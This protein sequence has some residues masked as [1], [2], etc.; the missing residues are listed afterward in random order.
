M[1][2]LLALIV[3]TLFF[4]GFGSAEAQESEIEALRAAVEQLR[5]D[6]D[7]RIAELERRLAVA[8]QSAMQAKRTTQSTKGLQAG[9]PAGNTGSSAFNPAIGVIFQGQA[10]NFSRN[11]DDYAIPGF[12]FGGEAGPVDEGLGI[13]ETELIL[14]ANVDDKFTAWLTV[15][16][17]LED[18]ESVVEI[19]EAWVEATALP[20]GLGMKFGRFFSGIGYLNSKHAHTWDFVDQPLPYQA[21]LGDQFLDNGLQFRWLAPTDLYM[22]FGGEVFQGSRYPAGGNADSGF[23]S[24]SLF[25]KFGGDVGANS[26]WLAGISYLDATAIDR[27]SGDEDDPLV[28][29]GD[30]QLTGAQFVWKWSPNGNWKQKN[31]VF[32]SEFFWRSEDGNYTLPGGTPLLYDVDQT[33]WY[34]QAVYQ[35]VPRWRFGGRVDGLSTDSPGPLFDDSVLSRPGSNPMRYSMMA[36]WSNSEFSRLRLQFTRDEAGPLDDTQWGIQYIHSIGAH[37]AHAF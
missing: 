20:A 21:F 8:E 34:A 4:A 22:E 27:P 12:P 16:L 32:Q 5:A 1:R 7:A 33:G 6:Y 23:G 30:S 35:P 14:N 9:T 24:Y 37:G 25:A 36:D 18:G 3:V 26:S 15:A 28:F 17:A 29:N 2:G 13:G 10:W 19:E 11:P 31:F